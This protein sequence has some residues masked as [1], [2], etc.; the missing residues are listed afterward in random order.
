MKKLL[1]LTLALIVLPLQ[2][3]ASRILQHGNA[4]NGHITI[5]EVRGHSGITNMGWFVFH[6]GGP[7]VAVRTQI[8]SWANTRREHYRSNITSNLDQ[9]QLQHIQN[10]PWNL[11]FRWYFVAKNNAGAILDSGFLFDNNPNITWD[12]E[13]NFLSSAD[14]VN[15]TVEHPRNLIIL[16][17]DGAQGDKR[18]FTQRWINSQRREAITGTASITYFGWERLILIRDKNTGAIIDIGFL[19]YDNTGRTSDVIAPISWL[20]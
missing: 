6:F 12:S 13:A 2:A 8:Q 3:Y 9:W 16:T 5:E 17:L 20:E 15:V 19:D 18:G 14:R 10:N 1:V 7:P 4:G 11:H